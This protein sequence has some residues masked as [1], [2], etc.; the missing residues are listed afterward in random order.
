MTDLLRRRLPFLCSLGVQ[1]DQ[2]VG[3]CKPPTFCL[4]RSLSHHP[5]RPLHAPPAAPVCECG[6][7]LTGRDIPDLFY[8]VHFSCLQYTHKPGD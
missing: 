7:G 6:S 5:P 1:Y 2:C 3:N 4:L 8:S